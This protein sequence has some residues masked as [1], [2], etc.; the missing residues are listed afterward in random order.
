M[1]LKYQASVNDLFD[2][3]LQ[4]S[5]RSGYPERMQ[6][7]IQAAMN[8][9]ALLRVSQ[10]RWFPL[11]EYTSTSFNHPALVRFNTG[12]V[13]SVKSGTRVDGATHWAPIPPLPEPPVL[14]QEQKDEEAW[15][16]WWNKDT[17]WD[18]LERAAFLAGLAAARGQ[19]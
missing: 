16:T 1:S 18:G 14:T 15:R 7:A 3:E 10:F 5:L 6:R 8:E 4:A 11:M 9:I 13:L 12:E 2:G 17:T 19:K